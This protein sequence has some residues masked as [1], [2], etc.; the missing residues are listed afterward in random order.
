M[1]A[2]KAASR[3]AGAMADDAKLL[4]G[5]WKITAL[6]MN[7]APMPSIMLN[8]AKIV[9]DGMRFSALGMGAVYSGQM[10]LDTKVKP[11][12]FSVKFDGDGP[13]SGRTNNAIYEL[14]GDA[15]RICVHVG[16]GPTP[17]A[18]KTQPG[19]GCAYETLVRE[20]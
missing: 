4:Q 11:K 12:R 13:E 14:D 8:N 18:F 20:N 2:R 5:T 19:D 16:G 17:T 7:G 15:W 1:V 9:I 3:Y 10:S 6:E